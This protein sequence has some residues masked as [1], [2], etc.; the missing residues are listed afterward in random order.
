M[1]ARQRLRPVKVSL[2]ICLAGF[3]ALSVLLCVSGSARRTKTALG[4]RQQVGQLYPVAWLRPRC[5][6]HVALE[7]LLFI[8]ASRT[9]QY[10]HMRGSCTCLA[11]THLQWSREQAAMQ[12]AA[13][14]AMQH[15]KCVKVNACRTQSHA[16]KAQCSLCH[17]TNIH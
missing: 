4:G 16:R 10:A 15:V 12:S 8:Q 7:K 3:L 5:D 14:N 17:H 9:S 13:W 11:Y 2:S 6:S 1:A